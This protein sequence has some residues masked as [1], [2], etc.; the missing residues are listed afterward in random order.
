MEMRERSTGPTKVEQCDF[1]LLDDLPLTPLPELVNLFDNGKNLL[2]RKN[3]DF[4]PLQQWN[5]KTLGFVMDPNDDG[6]LLQKFPLLYRHGDVVADSITIISD[7]KLRSNPN[8]YDHFNR[9]SLPLNLSSEQL[10]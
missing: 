5:E 9:K 10:L 1:V 8:K 3:G 4:I 2:R 7:A 6:R